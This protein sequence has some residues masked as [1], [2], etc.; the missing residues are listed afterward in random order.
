MDYVT[1]KLPQNLITEIDNYISIPSR[2]YT[3]RTDLVKDALRQFL[4]NNYG[5]EDASE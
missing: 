3:S 5:G 4:K 1:I 2:G